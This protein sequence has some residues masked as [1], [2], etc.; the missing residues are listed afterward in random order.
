MDLVCLGAKTMQQRKKHTNEGRQVS[1]SQSTAIIS[2]I[3]LFVIFNASTFRVNEW[4]QAI[5]TQ[6]GKIQGEPVTKAGLQFKIPFLQDVR[7][8]DKRILT[9]DGKPEQVPTKDKKYIWVDTTARWRIVDSIK[10]LQTVQDERRATRRITSILEGKT[11]NIVSKFNLV[12]TVRNT[13]AILE[14]PAEDEDVEDKITGEI[15]AIKVGREK[16]STMITEEAR[17]EINSLGIELIDVLIRRIAYEKSVEN[18]VFDRMISERNRVAERI[19][20]IG[21]GEEA[22]ISGTLN[23]DLKKIESEAYKKSKVIRGKA[24]AQAIKIYAD[25]IK[26]GPQF[27]DFN[28]TL[29]AYKSSLPGRANFVISTDS[30]FFKILDKASAN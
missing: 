19:R 25:A 26:K 15:E 17:K 18:K 1:K 24:E 30:K 14:A 20:S 21:K 2:I 28:Q 13:N 3:A 9:W 22:K 7:F 5:I 4:E 16:L 6:F 23:L 27:Y 11:K 10:F 8:F 29:D 12:E